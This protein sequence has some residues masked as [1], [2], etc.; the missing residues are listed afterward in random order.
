MF[1]SFLLVFAL[2]QRG[3]AQKISTDDPNDPSNG[4]NFTMSVDGVMKTVGLM[5]DAQWRWVHT[6]DFQTCN[7]D[8]EASF[9]E[10]C[11][12]QGL[13]ADDY[14]NNYG[15]FV[16]ENDV[17][18]QFATL[19]PFEGSQPGYGSRMFV[20]DPEEGGY[21]N[22]D[23][24]GKELSFTIDLSNVPGGMNAAIYLVSMDMSGNLNATYSDGNKNVAGWT[25]G[26][27]YCDAQCP[28]DLNFVQGAG[29]NSGGA[30]QSCCPEMDLLEANRLAA[31]FTAHP[32]T[33]DGPTVCDT[34]AEECSTKPCD[35]VGGDMN[36]FRSMG[37][38]SELFNLVDTTGPVTV[39]TRFE[40]DAAT[41]N[42]TAIQQTLEAAGASVTESLTDDKVASQK[43][44]YDEPNDFGETFGGVAQMGAALAKGMVL[45]LS[46]WDDASTNMNWLDSCAVAEYQTYDCS[47]NA[48]FSDPAMWASAFEAD[49]AGAWRGPADFYPDVFSSY[50]T[51]EITFTN[52]AIPTKWKVRNPKGHKR[53]NA[54]PD[55]T[56]VFI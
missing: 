13:S 55:K 50:R 20:T 41:G 28:T 12:V 37:P 42:L 7:D 34:G 2:S 26:L 56:L 27:G 17:H 33:S 19:P 9:N 10:G 6:E 38:G 53:E 24:L 43:V 29:W 21:M 35:G 54:T 15:I 3:C 49:G 22:F 46:I 1:R 31:V 16:E 44:L 23:L 36:Q 32:C 48:D 14:K 4:L 30:L 8:L 40:V 51:N 39:R 11:I 52:P 5:L 47:T 25:R 45:V 18:I